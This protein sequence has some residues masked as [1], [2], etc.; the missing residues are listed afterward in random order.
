M[1]GEPLDRVFAQDNADLA[2]EY[3]ARLNDYRRSLENAST[4]EL[5]LVYHAEPLD[6]S[7]DLAR[8]SITSDRVD[9]YR[10]AVTSA[11]AP[12]TGSARGAPRHVETRSFDTP[13]LRNVTRRG[14]ASQPRRGPRASVSTLTT[15]GDLRL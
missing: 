14:H 2:N 8:E 12:D 6:V 5:L 11:S 4:M 1:I 13:L 7:A 9:R 15:D 3:H 10:Q